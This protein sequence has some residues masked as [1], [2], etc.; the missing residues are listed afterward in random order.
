M[1]AHSDFLLTIMLWQVT[2]GLII[3]LPFALPVVVVKNMPV[4]K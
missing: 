2:R 1:Q 4:G 3:P